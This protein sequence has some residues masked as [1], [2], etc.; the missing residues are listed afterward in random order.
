MTIRDGFEGYDRT[1][2]ACYDRSTPDNLHLGILESQIEET[3]KPVDWH[4]LRSQKQY[5]HRS[6][7]SIVKG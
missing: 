6:D 4:A 7:E 2:D 1:M 5:H 3:N